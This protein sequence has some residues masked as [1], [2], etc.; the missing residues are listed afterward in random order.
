[1]T[2]NT[3]IEWTDAT[4]NPIN[5]CTRVSAGCVNCYAE[6]VAHRFSGEGQQYDGLTKLVGDEPRWTGKINRASDQ[7]FFKPLHWKR[8][9]KIF[10][11]SM[12]DLF[13]ESV[14][15]D[16][17]DQIFAIMAFSPQHTFQVLTKRP[18]RMREYLSDSNR[19]K[20]I[21]F[22]PRRYGILDQISLAWPL[23][24]VWLGVSVEDQATAK[25]RIPIL[26]DTTAAKRFISAEPLLGPIDI[27]YWV[28]TKAEFIAAVNRAADSL[29]ITTEEAESGIEKYTPLD[30]VIV[31]GESGPNARPMHPDW[32]RQIRD[33]CAAA[34]VP[35]FFKQWGE[36]LPI[37]E[38]KDDLDMRGYWTI[39]KSKERILNLAG[40][41]GFHGECVTKVRK[42]GKKDAGSRLDGIEHKEL[43][44]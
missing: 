35:F 31:G 5:G 29:M 39:N 9:R 41:H 4:W 13:H 10:V 23:P 18:E 2:D 34:N 20:K 38:T 7:T 27:K 21:I 12:S 3:K 33:D 19:L 42:V 36:W 24:N 16:L 28:E 25:E 32:A 1:M 26:L 17:I 44:K 40:G 11:N 30:W 14:S 43:P 37:L 15:D 22:A 6:K 8:P